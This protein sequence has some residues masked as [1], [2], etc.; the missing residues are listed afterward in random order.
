MKALR[1]WIGR[2]VAE[3]IKGVLQL[4]KGWMLWM[5]RINPW[6]DMGGAEKILNR[7]WDEDVFYL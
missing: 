7:W 6:N 3:A 2:L 4:V 1:N 5:A